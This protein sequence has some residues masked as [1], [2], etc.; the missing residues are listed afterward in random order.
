MTLDDDDSITLIV[1]L[2]RIMKSSLFY[3]IYRRLKNWLNDS[4]TM[5]QTARKWTVEE[6]KAFS[7]WDQKRKDNKLGSPV[8]FNSADGLM[9]WLRS[10]SK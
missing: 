5:Q 3:T 2:D 6:V 8:V 10:E 4:I 9:K 7:E 1:A